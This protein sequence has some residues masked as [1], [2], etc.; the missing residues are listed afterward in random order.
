MER[1]P[2]AGWVPLTLSMASGTENTRWQ[3]LL[4]GDTRGCWASKA[5]CWCHLRGD[6]G[7]SCLTRPFEEIITPW[8]RCGLSHL[9]VQ[10]L[11][12]PFIGW[13]EGQ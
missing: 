5:W 12:G 11:S 6:C 13:M 2:P 4:V 3:P 7:Q 8:W 1:H 9:L 10:V